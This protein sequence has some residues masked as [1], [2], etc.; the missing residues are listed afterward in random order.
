MSN[1]TF[2]SANPVDSPADTTP[3]INEF[4]QKHDEGQQVVEL[5]GTA[6]ASFQG[7][8]LLIESDEDDES[9]VVEEVLAV[10]ATFDATGLYVLDVSSISDHWDDHSHTYMLVSRFTGADETDLDMDNDGTPDNTGSLG[11]VYDSIAI[12]LAATARLYAGA[13]GGTDLTFAG[14]RASLVFRGRGT[15]AVFQVVGGAA[16]TAGGAAAAS[17]F[18]GADVSNATFGSPNPLD[19]PGDTTPLISEFQPVVEDEGEVTPSSSGSGTQMFEVTGTPGTEFSGFLLVVESDNDDEAGVVEQ[20]EPVS[21]TFD[22]NGYLVVTVAAFEEHSHTFMLVASFS[23]AAEVTDLDT[24]NDGTPDSTST[25]G[26]IYDAIGVPITNDTLLYGAAV[27]GTDLPYQGGIPSLVFRGTGS[28]EWFNV[29]DDAVYTE[30]GTDVT[31]QFADVD[32]SNP[33]F[34]GDNPFAP[35]S[36]DDGDDGL[37]DASLAG[38]VVGSVVGL[39]AVGVLAFTVLNR[40][41]RPFTPIPADKGEQAA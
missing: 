14:T 35:A 18:G 32:L 22:T 30:D 33:S 11:F 15:D 8:F 7:Y 37:S 29:V 10:D 12:P 3:R 28:G 2:G 36:E 25:V 23:G 13:V 20:V 1:A 5:A 40:P 21:G 17:A 6:G 24:N 27:G 26:Y 41:S 19:A 34:G 38:I 16:L 4:L 39:I 9:G 31:S